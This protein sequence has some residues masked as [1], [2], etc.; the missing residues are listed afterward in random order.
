MIVQW[1]EIGLDIFIF[2]V[3][4]SELVHMYFWKSND[5]KGMGYLPV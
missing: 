1:F 4:L 5:L 3:G 2:S